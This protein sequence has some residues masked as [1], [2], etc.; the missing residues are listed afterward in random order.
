MTEQLYTF[1]YAQG[2]AIV[3]RLRHRVISVAV[4]VAASGARI[5]AYMGRC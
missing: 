4:L 2:P 5:A 1:T 3:A